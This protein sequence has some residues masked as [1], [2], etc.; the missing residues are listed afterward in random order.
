MVTRDVIAET[1]NDEAARNEKIIAWLRFGLTLA[2][3]PDFL[4]PMVLPLV[5][6]LDAACLAYLVVALAATYRWEHW[7]G[8][9]YVIVTLDSAVLLYLA[10]VNLDDIDPTTNFLYLALCACLLIVT[11]AIRMSRGS[12]AYATVLVAAMFAVVLWWQPVPIIVAVSAIVVVVL[13]GC[14]SFFVMARL[15]GLLAEVTRKEQLSRFLSPE[16][17]EQAMRDPALLQLG[18][19]RQSVTEIGRAHV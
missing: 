10:I 16:L 17:V 2:I 18:G 11:A 8:F 3:V 7:P 13:L 14:L 9:K 15:S 6:W 12:V 4:D 1:I 19:K 5:L